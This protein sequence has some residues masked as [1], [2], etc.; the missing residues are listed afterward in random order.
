MTD[1]R[2]NPSRPDDRFRR[3]V[4]FACPALTSPEGPPP[5]RMEKYKAP[6]GSFA[7]YKPPGWAVDVKA[8][9]ADRIVTVSD[10][11]ADRS[12]S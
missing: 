9:G 4:L 8:I 2:R 5:A 11:G 10:P 7:L 6:D 1:D 3:L 12:P